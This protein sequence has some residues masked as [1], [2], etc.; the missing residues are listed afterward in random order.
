[1][2]SRA[3]PS[4][5][6]SDSTWSPSPR[7]RSRVLAFADDRGW[8]R[9]RLV[10]SLGTSFSRDYQGES[11]EGHQRPM[12]NVSGVRAGR[13]ATHGAR[14]C[15]TRRPTRGRIPATSAPSRRSGTCSTS[16]LRAAST[17]WNE[18]LAY[19]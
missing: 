5:S 18:Q 10:S 2:S 8:R 9:L 1:M 14:S 7:R 16:P 13:S 15:C 3:R 17:D 19:G 4:T 6:R 12:L 11:P